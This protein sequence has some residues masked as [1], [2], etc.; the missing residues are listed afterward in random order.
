VDLGEA[1][2]E[3]SL[4]FGFDGI[5][6]F[7]ERAT[8]FRRSLAEVAQR[9]GDLALLSEYLRAFRAKLVL[10]LGPVE[11]LVSSSR[12]GVEVGGVRHD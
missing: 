9:G 6:A 4:D 1:G 10:G 7:A 3:G 5:D 12:E 11:P 2:F 8:G